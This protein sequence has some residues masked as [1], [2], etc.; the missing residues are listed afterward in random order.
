M[1]GRGSRYR[2]FGYETPKPF[3]QVLGKPMFIWAIEGL[4]ISGLDRQIDKV[5]LVVLEEDAKLNDLDSVI[6]DYGLQVELVLIPEVTE[7]QL[8]SVLKAS[9]FLLESDQEVLVIP[10]DTIVRHE[11]FV[12]KEDCDGLISVIEQEGDR[13][14][15]ARFDE[16]YKVLEVAEKK[17]I[18][19]FASTGWYYFKSS[20]QFYSFATDLVEGNEK[21]HGEYYIMPLYNS[22]IK[23]GLSLKVIMAAEMHDLGTPE[24]KRIFENSEKNE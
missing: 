9:S 21:T 22:Y 15:F 11:Q 3:I 5:V 16:D 4:K 23:H 2:D 17:R 12:N 20:M 14:S 18:S 24:A 13:W 1:A 6:R 10:S 8:V 7:G 19:S